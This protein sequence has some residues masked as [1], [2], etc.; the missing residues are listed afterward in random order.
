[1]A[2]TKIKMDVEMRIVK[3]SVQTDEPKELFVK[4]Y[5][6]SQNVKT[7]KR[8]VDQQNPVVDFSKKEGTFKLAARF[9]QTGE[10]QYERD[11]NKLELYC[12]N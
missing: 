6:G 1:M 10:G 11:E 2:G 5:R 8:S 3:A 9:T 7:K 4:W 12:E